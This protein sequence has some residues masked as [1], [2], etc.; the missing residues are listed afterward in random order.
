[1][2]VAEAVSFT[3]D[4]EPV[5]LEPGAPVVLAD[6][7]RHGA[8]RTSVR[9]ACDQG[10]CG[11]CTVLLD[12]APITACSAL[13]ETVRGKTVTT[14]QGLRASGAGPTAVQRAFVE[15]HAFQCGMC[16]PGMILLAEALLDRTPNP[17]RPE[18]RAWMG[19]NV[20]RCTGYRAIEDA[21]LTAARLRIAGPGVPDRPW[22]PEQTAKVF[23]RP[24][25]T[26]D[27]S[28]PGMLEAKILRSPHAHA[29]ILGVHTA[30]A[31]ALP[32]VYAVVTGADVAA[33]PEPFYGLWIK[34]QPLLAIDRVRYEG[35]PVAAVAA[36]D[37]ATALRALALIEVD[38]QLLPAAPT[39]DEALADGATPLFDTPSLGGIPAHGAGVTCEKEPAANILYQFHHRVGDVEAEFAG[40]DHVFEDIFHF[41]RMSHVPLEQMIT[42]AR[43]MG[44]GFEL[45]SSNQDPFLLRQD[46]AEIFGVPEHLV[47]VHTL[48]IG[49]AFGMN[50]F[51][52]L[53]P[54]TALLARKADR[55]VRLA[56]TMDE[57]LVTLSQHAARLH[58]KTAVTSNGKLLARQSRILLDGGAYAD[59]SALVTDKVGYRIG[60]PYRWRALD[61]HARAVRTNTV[62]AGSFRGFGGTQASWASES[63]MDMIA[64][65]L[66]LDPVEFRNRNLLAPSEPFR[67]GDSGI[68]CDLAAGLATVAE[69]IGWGRR[70]TSTE[71]HLARGKGVAI[72]F[73]DAGGQGRYA[74]ARIKVLPGGDAVISCA[75]VDMGQGATEAFR[76]I[77]AKVLDM[78]PHRVSRAEIDTDQT[79]FDQ[80]THASSATAVTG[81]AIRRAAEAVRARII[82]FAAE[83]LDTPA[84]TLG[85]ADGAIR[86]GNEAIPLK[87]LVRAYYGGLGAEFTGDG[88]FKVPTDPGA[89]LNA[90]IVY[91]MPNWVGA[92][93]EVD[94]QTGKI[95]LLHLACAADAGRAL[96]PEAVRGQIEGAA[97]QAVGQS[98]YE[99]LV[100]DGPHLVTDTPQRYRMPLSTDLPTRFE[101]IIL[102]HSLGRGPFGAKG[103]GEAGIL[104]VAAAIANAVEDAID[105]RITSL[106]L[107]AD[108]VLAAL[109][110]RSM[111][112]QEPE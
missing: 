26:S 95:T 30:A 62:P 97:M 86:R 108:K 107:T 7:L 102:E 36:R 39:L 2:T 23:G 4:G 38:Y 89:A 101:A 75:T 71:P 67:P 22:R 19:A 47:R 17:T 27:L 112:A 94:T 106:P 99:Q 66:G 11:A 103:V 72:G 42:L 53:E 48:P 21:V 60:G 14:L 98:L 77:V 76:R 24:F 105:V 15:E 64:R 92:E 55:A 29:R 74:K 70:K 18:V 43:P 110:A 69:R 20:C 83:R 65:R 1:M 54:L 31:R 40:A 79:D 46:I 37:A 32:G 96:V 44:D 56:L 12:G 34:D 33:L 88:E 49:G 93:V 84:E 68:D 45:W 9:V 13:T 63:Q 58:L 10:V 111:A 52:K 109:D 91:W 35:D 78:D 81:E 57:G 90:Q 87:Q 6:A 85:Y 16:T 73:K 8:G 50:S 80:G 51:C 82:G 100:Y 61:S 28:L 25:Y 59:A 41:S 5:T 104:G 3:L